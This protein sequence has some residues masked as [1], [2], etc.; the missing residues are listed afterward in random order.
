MPNEPTHL[1][2]GHLSTRKWRIRGYWSETNAFT[3]AIYAA[4]G[5]PAS[6]PADYMDG[7]MDCNIEIQGTNALV[8]FNDNCGPTLYWHKSVDLVSPHT[9]WSV[10]SLKDSRTEAEWKQWVADNF[11]GGILDD[12][13]DNEVFMINPTPKAPVYG[14]IGFAPMSATTVIIPAATLPAL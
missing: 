12:F 5:S 9:G 2:I 4:L 13:E 11:S 6:R 7:D 8:T 3:R 1:Q 14:I 10:W